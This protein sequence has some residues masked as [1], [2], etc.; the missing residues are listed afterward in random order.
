MTLRLIGF[1]MFATA[2]F[3]VAASAA[4][5][6]EVPRA[7]DGHPDLSGIWTQRDNHP[8]GAS[9]RA[10]RQRVFHGAGSN[11]IRKGSCA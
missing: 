2:L 4:S 5:P 3:V 6:K 8:V 9:P 7:A 10:C 11:P 1:S